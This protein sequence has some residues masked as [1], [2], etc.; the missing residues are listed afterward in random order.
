MEAVTYIYVYYNNR[1][2]F[3][4]GGG[5]GGGGGGAIMH[6]PT[7]WIFLYFCL[8][9][10]FAGTGLAGSQSQRG[11]DPTSSLDHEIQSNNMNMACVELAFAR[12]TLYIAISSIYH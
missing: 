2:V 4:G 1:A 9:P 5:G 10:F 11:Q 6:A 7:F 8:L 3:L 12:P